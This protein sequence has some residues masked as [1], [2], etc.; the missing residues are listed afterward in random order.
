MKREWKDKEDL[1]EEEI[2]TF[3][4]TVLKLQSQVEQETIV[5]QNEKNS[6]VH[7]LKIRESTILD[8]EKNL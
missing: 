6:L 3:K 5:N 7:E 2:K 8:L 4:N 1:M